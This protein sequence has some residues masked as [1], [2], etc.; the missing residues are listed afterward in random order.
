M[1][2]AGVD[3]P[4]CLARVARNTRV[5]HASTVVHPILIEPVPLNGIFVCYSGGLGAVAFIHS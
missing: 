2:K 5:V 4:I 3:G 1:L